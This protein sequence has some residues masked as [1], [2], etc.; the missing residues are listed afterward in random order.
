MIASYGY[1]I[2]FGL[3][4]LE[5]SG[6]PLPGEVALISAAIYAGATHRIDISLVILA[7]AAGAVFGDNLGFW[8]GRGAGL[9]LL[10]RYGRYLRLDERRLKL[11]QYLFLQYGGPIVFFGRFVAVLRAFAALLAGANGMAWRRFLLFNA[12]GGVLWA[13]LYGGGAYLFG[14]AIHPIAGIASIAT[15][16]LALAGMS[17]L[18]MVFS[19]HERAPEIRGRTRPARP[20]AASSV[21]VTPHHAV[22]KPAIARYAGSGWRRDAYRGCKE[23]D[24]AC[25]L[26]VTCVSGTVPSQPPPSARKRLTMACMCV[27]RT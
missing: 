27:R 7:G 21:A 8:L 11:G 20:A 24:A 10:L 6:I 16:G 13:T 12:A 22:S 19:R 3:V 17:A 5:S 25:Y 26:L 4:A 18:Y 1:W 23:I 2:V 9:R 15:L 14:Q